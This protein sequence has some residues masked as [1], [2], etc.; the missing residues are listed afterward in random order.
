MIQ[1]VYYAIISVVVLL[2]LYNAV[3]KRPVN[4]LVCVAIVLVT[5]A[6]R[7]LHIK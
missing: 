2:L 3:K 7:A 5:F 4:E 1:I 6:L